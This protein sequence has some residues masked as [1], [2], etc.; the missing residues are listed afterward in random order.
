MCV[1]Y[2]YFSTIFPSPKIQAIV[3]KIV[4]KKWLKSLKYKALS[5]FLKNEQNNVQ[6]YFCHQGNK[7]YP[8]E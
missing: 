6:C 2:T 5:H 3:D 8:Q 7:T 4:A 1:K